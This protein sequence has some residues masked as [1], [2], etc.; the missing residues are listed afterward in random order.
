MCG[1]PAPL[2]RPLNA[3]SFF[4]YRRKQLVGLA[5]RY[6]V[7]AIYEGRMFTAIGGLISYGIH[8]AAV[9][10]QAGVY[11]GRILKALPPDDRNI[12]SAG[13]IYVKYRSKQC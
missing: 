3:D 9:A 12:R 5:S 13:E 10:R 1:L 7:P 8:S 2:R 6:A 11:A 4:I